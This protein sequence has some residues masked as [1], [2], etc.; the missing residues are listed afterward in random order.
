M[1]WITSRNLYQEKIVDPRT[2][3]ER[4]VSVKINGTSEKAKQEALKR[5]TER[6]EKLSDPH[7]RLSIAIDNYIRESERSLKPSS[8]RK[9]RIELE[10]FLNVVG[11]AD[12]DV[13][14]AGYIRK[15]LL[16]SGKEN[17]TLNGYLKVFK[18]FWMWAYRN[19]LVQSREVFD[20]LQSFQDSPKKERIQ[21]KYLEPKELSKLLDSMKET[22][23]KLVTEFL[24]LSGL[25]IGELASLTKSDISNGYIHVNKTYDAN[26]KVVTSAKTYSS[27]R[28][29]YIQDE[30]KDCIN[31]MNEYC[32]WQEEILGYTSM[33]FFPGPDGSY[34]EYYTYRK[35]LAENSEKV[36]GRKVVPHS[37][38]HTHCSVLASRGMSL[39][40][41]SDR[42]GHSDSKITKE[43]Y[44]HKLEEL[45]EKENRQLD[46]IHF[47][48]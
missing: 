48:G 2:G 32:K 39:Q 16:D 6:I 4:V 33:L 35:Y 21:D 23:W 38:R 46:A 29:V 30:L 8:V 10:Q 15:K 40:S 27:Q 18:T 28:E 43:I 24:A 42:L 47:V 44:L 9:M 5:L 25:R 7:I 45:K 31:R 41:I 11:D 37:L 3:L 34:M 17:R 19:D 14:S 1:A 13:L 26:N 12:M 36:L 20:K 22:R